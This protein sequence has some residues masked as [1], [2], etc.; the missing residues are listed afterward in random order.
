MMLV[1]VLGKDVDKE[2]Q[3]TDN[4]SIVDGMAEVVVV[5]VGVASEVI[6]VTME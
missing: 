5:F 6:V 3:H 1:E 4:C 2:E